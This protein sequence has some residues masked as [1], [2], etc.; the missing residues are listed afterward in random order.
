MHVTWLQVYQVS[1]KNL[2]LRWC[3]STV[4]GTNSRLQAGEL[5]IVHIVATDPEKISRVEFWVNDTLIAKELSPLENGI[6]PFPLVT[7]WTP[8]TSGQ[9][10]LVARAFNREGRQAYSTI[11]LNVGSESALSGPDRDNDGFPDDMDECPDTW[12][13]GPVGCPVD[14]PDID[15]DGVED[16]LDE[17][18]E[19]PGDFIAEGCPDSDLDGVPD[20]QDIC[21]DAI[22][23]ARIPGRSWLPGGRCG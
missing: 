3:I 14:I 16:T 23:A 7:D 15:G 21:P 2:H 4:Q 9:Y 20:E 6:S 8:P 18:P 5:E 11:R 1:I 12:G 17:C 22:G 13:V 19:V 10:K